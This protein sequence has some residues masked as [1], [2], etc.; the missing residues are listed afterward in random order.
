M[1]R[2]LARFAVAGFCLLSLLAAVGTSCLWWECRRG[3]GAEGKPQ[4][5]KLRAVPR[6]IPLRRP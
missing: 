3:A 6:R 1:I 5:V 4:S 2:R